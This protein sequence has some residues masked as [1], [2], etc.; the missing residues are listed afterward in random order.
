MSEYRIVVEVK[1][2]KASDKA[3]TASKD[4]TTKTNN[5]VTSPK[6]KGNQNGDRKKSP[7]AQTIASMVRNPTS[8]LMHLGKSVPFIGAAIVASQVAVQATDYGMDISST[9]T[10]DYSGKMKW[11]NF[12]GTMKAVLNPVQSA[13]SYGRWEAE[14]YKAN[15]SQSLQRELMGT[16]DLGGEGTLKL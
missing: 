9:L 13:L 5:E 11:D 15:V 12:K 8:A 14:R 1:Q 4:G 7:S 2:P 6:N 16:A 3:T 10:G